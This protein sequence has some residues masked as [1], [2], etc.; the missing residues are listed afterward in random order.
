MSGGRRGRAGHGSG[1]RL[2]DEE[3]GLMRRGRKEPMRRGSMDS[4][5]LRPIGIL[6]TVLTLG[7]FP[8]LALGQGRDLQLPRG[9]GTYPTGDLFIRNLDAVWTATGRVLENTSILIRGGKIEAMG[10]DIPAPDGVRVIDGEGL[11]AIPGLVDEH[12]HTAMIGTNEGTVPVSAEVRVLDVLDPEGLTIYRSLSGGVTTARIMHGSAN[13]IGGTSAV[14]KMRWGMDSADQLVFDGAPRFV[15]FALG[16]NVTQKA[17]AGRA[18]PTRFPASRQGVEALYV[19]AF[20]AAREYKAEWETYRRNPERFRVPPR[21]DLRLETLVDVLDRRVEVHAHSYRADEIL[22]L[23]RVAERFGF[24]IDVQT[25]VLEGFRVAKEMAEHGAGGSTFSDWWHYKLEAYDAIPHNAAIMHRQGVLTALNS[26]ISW[27]QAFMIYEFP[28]AVKWGGVSKEDALRMLT[29]YPARMMHIQDRVGTLEVGKD[30]DVVL[31]NGDPFDTFVRVEKTIVD[32][33]VYYDVHDEAGTRKEPFDPLPPLPLTGLGPGNLTDTRV[34]SGYD[35]S[36]ATELLDGASFVLAGGTVHPVARPVIEDGVVI[37]RA[38]RITAVGTASQISVPDDLVRI[39]VTGKHVYPGMIDPLTNL[40]IY[41]FGAVGQAADMSETGAFNPHVRAISAVVPYSA[42]INVARAN[43]ITAAL[44][45]QTSGVIQGTAGVVQ[46]RGDTYERMSVKPEAALMVA[47]PAPRQAP[48]SWAEWEVFDLHGGGEDAAGG[49][50]PFFA[51]AAFQPD[52]FVLPDELPRRPAPSLQPGGNGEPTPT[53]QGERMES[54][55][56]LFKRAQVFAGSR[57]VAQDPT[58]PFEVNVRGGE[59][60][61]L[62]AL[63]PAIRGEMPVLFQADSEWQLRTLFLFLEEFP[64]L[65]AV[66]VG[67]TEAFKVAE[68]LAAR[69]LPVII[70]SAYAP[71]P[72]RDESILASYRNAAL[73]HSAGVKI[74]F[75]TGSTADVRKLPYHAA[76]SVA[77]G[78]PA[79]EGLKA[80]TLNAAEI[81]GVGDL[82]GS[83]EPGKRADIVVTD[84]SPLQ[85]LTR[86]HRMF[87]GGVEVDPRDNKHDALYR[88]FVDR[89]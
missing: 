6:L 79:E 52:P 4:E 2:T 32:G 55:V 37:V 54:L 14:I 72:G 29:T 76:H 73:L 56:A 17:A 87:I 63:V 85:A 15:K 59:R 70:T 21:R 35:A 44:V 42:A 86:I 81:L 66:V 74:A 7:V 88:E 25:H 31:L 48:G 82:L 71:T 84:G 19:Q 43:G 89:R 23:M 3:K 53:L 65:R 1:N 39:D 77:F 51:T 28:K 16:E 47:F 26:D 22:A 10:S 78:L 62:E 58:L 34:E 50:S 46:L 13:P 57:T 75:G 60:V 64:E 36:L 24:K 5:R 27:L 11:T 9:A 38:G 12:S 68:G 45:T 61:I 67:G 69:E 83:L 30:G 40:G 49:R 18:G 8:A 20:T 41:E 33:I 80:V